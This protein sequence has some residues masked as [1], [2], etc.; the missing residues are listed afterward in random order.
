MLPIKMM[1]RIEP[2][3][4]FDTKDKT[5]F[6]KRDDQLPHGG[7]KSRKYISLLPA[8]LE[9]GH[10]TVVLKGG[11]HSNHR[12]YFSKLLEHN[13]LTIG[14]EGFTVEE[15]GSQKESILGA[16]TLAREIPNTFD[17]I[18]IDA[19]TGFMAAALLNGVAAHVH[20]LQLAPLE[21]SK[22]Y[23]EWFGPY[24]RDRCSVHL[25]TKW[26]SF[27]AFTKPLLRFISEFTS[28]TGI[29]LD[30]IYSGKLFYFTPEITKN[31][32]GKI[33][34]IHQGVS[35]RTFTI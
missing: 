13:G 28:L 33:L 16:M 4:I 11:R 14:N 1:S 31:L 2:L 35:P 15:G 21:F 30:P 8:I 18:L 32:K 20:V 34:I 6:I 7:S 29:P 23:E 10:Q 17:H 25:P 9:S 5:F 27:G 26:R 24:P 22:A 19:G 3:P 12:Y